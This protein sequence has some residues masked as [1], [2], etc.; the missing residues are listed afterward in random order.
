[1]VMT[2]KR[3]VASLQESTMDPNSLTAILSVAVSTLPLDVLS[4]PKTVFVKVTCPSPLP[5]P[6]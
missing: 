2:G 3:S 6:Y 5:G 4:S 1:M